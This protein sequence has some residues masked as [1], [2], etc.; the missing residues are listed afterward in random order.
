MYYL[1]SSISEKGRKTVMFKYKGKGQ[2]KVGY[3]S[4][5]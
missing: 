1:L 3:S 2:Q 5:I 4:Y